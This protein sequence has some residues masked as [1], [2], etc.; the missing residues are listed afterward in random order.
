MRRFFEFLKR[1]DVDVDATLRLPQGPAHA[2]IRG[3]DGDW[4][5]LHLALRGALTG[6]EK[7]TSLDARYLVDLIRQVGLRYGDPAAAIAAAERNV[8]LHGDLAERVATPEALRD[9]SIS[10]NNLGQVARAQGE[11]PT[12]R[13]LYQEALSAAEAAAAGDDS[14]PFRELLAWLKAHPIG[15]APSQPTQEPLG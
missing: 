14:T 1:V 9:L 10:L 2:E 11:W 7:E 4:A 8:Q 3:A 15:E 6:L 13:T 12:A 5:G